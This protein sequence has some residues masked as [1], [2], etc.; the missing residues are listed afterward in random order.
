MRE[1]EIKRGIIKKGSNAGRKAPDKSLPVY[2]RTLGDYAGMPTIVLQPKPAVQAEI[3]IT[4]LYRGG[5]QGEIIKGKTVGG[6][7]ID[8]G[9]SEVKQDGNKSTAQMRDKYAS[10]D[11]HSLPEEGK[12]EYNRLQDRLN[13]EFD[14]GQEMAVVVPDAKK[15]LANRLEIY[16][17]KYS[18]GKYASAVNYS[19]GGYGLISSAAYPTRDKAINE[20]AKYVKEWVDRRLRN[21]SITNADKVIL[22]KIDKAL[23]PC[24]L[25]S[26]VFKLSE[27]INKNPGGESDA[28]AVSKPV[29]QA[30]TRIEEPQWPYEEYSAWSRQFAK[31]N[32]KSDLENRLAEVEK[33]LSKATASHLRAID[34]STS[35]QSNSQRR[36]QGRNVVSGL[37]DEKMALKNALEIHN[38]YPEKSKQIEKDEPE[39]AQAETARVL[40]PAPLVGIENDIPLDLATL[41]HYGT[42]WTPEVRGQQEVKGYISILQEDYKDLKKY[43]ATPEQ[44]S[45]LDNY[46]QTYRKGYAERLKKKLSADSRTMSSMITGPSNFPTARNQKRLNSAHNALTEMLSYRDFMLK[47]IK[48]TLNPRSISSSDPQALEKL[49]GKLT[50]LRENQKLMISANKIIRSGKDVEKRLKTE[51]GL[52]EDMIKEILAPDFAGRLGFAG[53]STQ[54][55]NAIIRATK[56]RIAELTK[57]SELPASSEVLFSG[58][59]VDLNALDNRVRIFFGEIPDEKT[60]KELKSRGFHWSPNNRAWQRKLTDNAKRATEDILGIK[61]DQPV[62]H[63]IN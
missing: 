2:Q 37:G 48:N 50:S 1:H 15:G 58:G 22:K 21:S 43:A 4:T 35:M 6:V 27:Q 9:S 55:N 28:G 18:D 60:R 34:K 30:L 57:K 23:T 19:T 39:A 29:Q 5:G 45:I 8:K 59:R 38:F 16:T 31:N 63:E 54:N 52:S 13:E 41:A 33:D 32:T 26:D 56:E 61:F 36:A 20:A 51:L 24:L 62:I 44:Q 49:Q 25:K 46:F 3:P 40:T 12:E 14:K 53:F 10:M 47:K 11:Y 42:S 17:Y 7:L